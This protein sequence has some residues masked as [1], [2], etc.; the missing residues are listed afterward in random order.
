MQC[1]A[2]R[3]S[4]PKQAAWHMALGKLCWHACM[5][6]L[7]NTDAL[8]NTEYFEAGGA[9]GEAAHLAALAL[10]QVAAREQ[11][12]EHGA[13]QRAQEGQVAQH[14]R[15]QSHLLRQSHILAATQD[16][17]TCHRHP[18]QLSAWNASTQARERATGRVATAL[19][20][21]TRSS[22]IGHLVRRT[23]IEAFAGRHHGRRHRV[24]R[25][26]QS[27]RAR[28]GAHGKAG[29]RTSYTMVERPMAPWR[30]RRRSRRSTGS[31]SASRSVSSTMPLP[32]SC[33]TNM[34]CAHACNGF[35]LWL[36]AMPLP[37]SC[38]TDMP[39]ARTGAHAQSTLESR[40]DLHTP[41]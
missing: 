32:H 28:C 37:Q 40:P 24:S 25:T 36:S 31:S 26:G 10:E 20:Q 35:E 18:T 38:C 3:R 5:H 16:A 22:L 23:T 4:A 21:H 13:R 19:H 30:S 39:C 34:P 11:R 9:E 33:C 29:A 6:A 17:S 15:A 12:L 14:L 7:L 1:L 41:Q 2:S 8:L 27:S